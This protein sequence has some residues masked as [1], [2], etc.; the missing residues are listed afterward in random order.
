MYRPNERK[1]S[2]Q[3]LDWS[4]L[5]T[6]GI[7]L[8]YSLVA[9]SSATHFQSFSEGDSWYIRRQAAF[10]LAS[11]IVV[12][13]SL[14]FDYRMLKD[15]A[16]FLY[17]G[18]LALLLL[19]SFVG[20]T[21]LGAQRWLQIGPISIQPSEFAKIAMIIAL[22]AK[23]E[24]LMNRIRGWREVIPIFI[25]VGVPA[26]LVLRQPDL[27]TA[28]VFGAILLGMVFVAGIPWRVLGTLAGVLAVAVP[29]FWPFMHDYQRKRI[30]V[31]FN[32]YEDP[33]GAGYHVIQS[34]I[35][36]G[37][38]ELFGKGLFSGPQSQLNFLPENH[39]DFIFSVIGEELGFIGGIILILTYGFL[40]YRTLR[41]SGEARDN[42][43]MLLGT[44]IASMW[45]F[46]LLVN[47]GMT[48][49]IMPVTGVPLPFISYGVS[50]L[51]TNMIGVAI[52]LNIWV[53]R[54]K[55]TF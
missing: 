29:V 8:I 12:W 5:I 39:T 26:V 34:Q 33:L 13:L 15:L 3:G 20:Q 30:L 43:G 32:P 22:A 18:T 40:L 49:G 16:P 7:L 1:R 48:M 55:I 19:V 53:R 6:I 54:K 37:S 21:A 31:L 23:I 24:P 14:K 41:I 9:I 10:I 25:Y 50:S 17:W 46:H 2:L 45:A 42:F 4:L 11:A 44:G 51:T 27:G 36:I 35:A 38:G 52:L 47:V 28:L